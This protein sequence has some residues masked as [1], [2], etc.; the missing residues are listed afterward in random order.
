MYRRPTQ[1]IAGNVYCS[2]VCYGK[3]Q[4]KPENVKSVRQP[5]LVVIKRALILVLIELELVSLIQN[6]TPTIKRTEAVC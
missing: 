5:I 3:K 2:F 6:P 4:Q 1:I